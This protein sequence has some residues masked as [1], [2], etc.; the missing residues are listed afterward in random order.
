MVRE[1]ATE[2]RGEL[3]DKGIELDRKGSEG[4]MGDKGDKGD[5]WR[6]LWVWTMGEVSLRHIGEGVE[7]GVS[8]GEIIPVCR[9][10]KV[11][12]S[13]NWVLMGRGWKVRDI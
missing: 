2:G 13:R 12:L 8:G 5:I 4:D 1:I 9:W 11:G 7:E 3:G 6:M 10:L